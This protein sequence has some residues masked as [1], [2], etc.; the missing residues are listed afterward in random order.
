MKQLHFTSPHSIWL[1]CGLQYEA[2]QIEPTTVV[3]Y[4]QVFHVRLKS[5]K[6]YRPSCGEGV[7]S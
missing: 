2:Y 4:M 5:Q 7:N 3:S 6:G 1:D